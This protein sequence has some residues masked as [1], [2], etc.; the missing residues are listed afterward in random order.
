ML[1]PFYTFSIYE[2][3][4]SPI[5]SI[6]QRITDLIE[7]SCLSQWNLLKE[8]FSGVLAEIISEW[9]EVLTVVSR[10]YRGEALSNEDKLWIKEI[11]EETGWDEDA[12]I[13]ELRNIGTD[14]SKRADKYRE[15]CEKY[16]EEANKHKEEGDTK[17]A[18]E[19]MWGAITALIKTYAAAK[20]TPIIHWDHGK[21]INFILN[22]IE[23]EYRD[24]F[25]RAF[26]GGEELHRHFYE[27]HLSK[28]AF[29]RMWEDAIKYFK[30]A[31]EIT[32][33]KLRDNHLSKNFR[34]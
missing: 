13:D 14:P 8:S 34:I 20:R 25:L 21:L 5:R 26:Q 19:K 32:M 15:L 2:F 10:L 9:P 17:Q 33:I 27:G 23:E 3:I 30:R 24:Q 6:P 1:E 11:V 22:N 12:V 4:S 16:F 29:E 28:E 31:K 18:G 7:I